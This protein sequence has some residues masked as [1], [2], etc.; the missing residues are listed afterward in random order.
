MSVARKL[1]RG[2]KARQVFKI[3]DGQYPVRSSVAMVAFVK[4]LPDPRL[5]SSLLLLFSALS[6]PCRVAATKRLPETE[7]YQIG[8]LSNRRGISGYLESIP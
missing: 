6:H 7:V 1:G 5:Y 8:A 4:M 2:Y 3:F